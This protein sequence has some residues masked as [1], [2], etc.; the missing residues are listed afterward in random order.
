M[1]AGRMCGL[2]ASACKTSLAE[3]G[4]L[5]ASAAVLLVPMTF[6]SAFRS[7]I[8]CALKRC[9]PYS[10]KAM[11][12]THKAA[13]VFTM[14]TY[15]ILWRSDSLRGHRMS[16]APPPFSFRNR[17]GK[18]QQ[19]RADFQV[20]AAGRTDIDGKPHAAILDQE[21]NH[22]AGLDEMIHVRDR[23]NA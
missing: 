10:A 17:A 7:C 3:F 14:V 1:Q 16:V 5:N 4:S 12:A 2:T 19:F 11:P 15:V 23:Q 18:G 20:C 13:N 9:T 22:S 21:L 6:A 8:C